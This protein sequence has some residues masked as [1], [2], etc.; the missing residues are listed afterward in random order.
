[1]KN[2]ITY[3]TLIADS[4]HAIGDLR[5]IADSGVDIDSTF[6][7]DDCKRLADEIDVAICTLQATRDSALQLI[8]RA[9][10]IVHRARQH[11]AITDVLDAITDVL[12]K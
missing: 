2:E 3:E 6:D 5:I 8:T 7:T 9:A 10:V 11:D 1:M 4:V 12:N